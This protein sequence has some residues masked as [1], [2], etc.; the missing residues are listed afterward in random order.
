[1]KKCKICGWHSDKCKNQNSK[2]YNQF[3][4]NITKCKSM[5]IDPNNIKNITH[6]GGNKK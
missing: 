3:L 6:L 5:L 4:E 1:M 2:N